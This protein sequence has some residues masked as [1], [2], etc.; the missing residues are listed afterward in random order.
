[1]AD[2]IKWQDVTTEVTRKVA[3]IQVWG[4]TH[5]GR[6][7]LALTAPGPIALM[8]LSEKV[9]GIAEAAVKAG[10]K[11]RKLDLSREYRGD[12]ARIKETAK[13]ALKDFEAAMD[14]A[15][16][17]AGSIVIDTHTDLWE[18]IRLA[19]FGT[20]TPKGVVSNLYGPVNA[21]WNGIISRHRAQNKT[22]LI[23]IGKTQEEYR[24]D[25]PT[26]RIVQAGKRDINYQGDVRIKT[27]RGKD[28]E[29]QAVIE[30]GWYNA[31]VEGFET[32]N[33]DC[34]IPYIMTL[35]TEKEENWK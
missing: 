26:G 29:F 28:G 20:V 22:N 5:T 25:K 7:T 3:I 34:N 10:K 35:I 17:W 1:M 27:K 18:M 4:E 16:K 8:H 15:Y 32:E 2:A 21:T 11:V 12:E 33:E 30:K 14:D 24:N 6:T 23:L 13:G 19:R 31:I 9:D